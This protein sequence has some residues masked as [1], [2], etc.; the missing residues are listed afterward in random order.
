MLTTEN[1]VRL[2]SRRFTIQIKQLH[3]ISHQ[4]YR[5]DSC[6]ARLPSEAC[7]KLVESPLDV[8]AIRKLL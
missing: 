6:A 5:L 4:V 8:I 3:Q 2:S 7:P 1:S